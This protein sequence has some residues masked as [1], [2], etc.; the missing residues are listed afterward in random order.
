MCGFINRPLCSLAHPA[1]GAEISI[2][3]VIIRSGDLIV[4]DRDGVT[5]MP[6]E[7]IPEALKGMQAVRERERNIEDRIA[8][9]MTMP[10]WVKEF[11]AGDRAKYIK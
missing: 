8:A 5:V 2:G 10:D 4:G 6:Q 1:L 7:K 9:G 11:L 3:G